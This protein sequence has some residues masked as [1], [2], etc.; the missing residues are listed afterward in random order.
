MN[1]G[2]A[3][4]LCRT[5][6]GYTQSKL[7]EKANISVSYLSLLEKGKRDPNL[8]TLQDISTALEVPTSILMFLASDKEELDG[9]SEE[10]AEKLSL[11]VLKLISA[12]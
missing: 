10:L 4:K 6:K 2:N 12:K 5:Q 11:T 3:I 8:S 7:S 9:I 1:I